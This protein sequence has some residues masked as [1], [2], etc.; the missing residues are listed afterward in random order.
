MTVLE[1]YQVM[2]QQYGLLAAGVTLDPSKPADAAKL[3]AAL[4]PG[5]TVQ[6][7]R[8]KNSWGALRDPRS[9][10]P[11]F[12]GYHDLYVDYL[13]GPITWC[14]DGE[15]GAACSGSAT[16]FQSVVLPPGF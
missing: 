10:A 2:T 4:L 12:P 3:A 1:D 8:V 13:N 9:S 16:P 11:G 6:F 14:E 15:Q 5:S 7:F